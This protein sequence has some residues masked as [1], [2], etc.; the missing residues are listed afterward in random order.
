MSILRAPIPEGSEWERIVLNSF[1][2]VEK[3]K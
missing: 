2:Q 1:G 3:Q